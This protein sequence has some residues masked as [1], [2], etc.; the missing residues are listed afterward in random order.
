MDRCWAMTPAFVESTA[1]G[2]VGALSYPHLGAAG[3][4]SYVLFPEL[5]NAGL[6]NAPALQYVLR[7]RCRIAF[8]QQL[9]RYV[10]TLTGQGVLSFPSANASD[11][12]LGGNY[13]VLAGDILIAV[14]TSDVSAR[15]HK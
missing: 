1:M 7:A 6:H 2:T 11:P 10:I 9:A 13:T 8:L 3:N 4:S 15:G 5:T 12:T 14:D